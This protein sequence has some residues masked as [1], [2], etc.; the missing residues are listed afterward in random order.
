MLLTC[1]NRAYASRRSQL[2]RAAK[3][4]GN[5]TFSRIVQ[6]DE[7]TIALLPGYGTIAPLLTDAS[8]SR[9][10]GFWAWKP[11]V[12]LAALEGLADDEALL[13]LD[14][15]LDL[16]CERGREREYGRFLQRIAPWTGRDV[17]AVPQPSSDSVERLWTKA[18]TLAH[19]GVLNNSAV[20]NSQQYF[21]GYFFLRKTPASVALVQRWLD[22]FRTPQLVND[23]PSVL[24][25]FHRFRGHRHDQSVWSVLR[26]L[27]PG[28]AVITDLTMKT[29]SRQKHPK[30]VA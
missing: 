27:H 5:A 17:T 30:G 28:T 23:A 14:A 16:K 9:G 12:V 2:V 26:K 13:Y 3:A 11:I 6:H 18:D 10:W 15:G 19:F 4:C 7:N 22:T 24:P 20:F 29:I 8:N 1:S 25:N 21:G